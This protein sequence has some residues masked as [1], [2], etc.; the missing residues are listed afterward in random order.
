MEG[1][2]RIP[3]QLPPL[4]EQMEGMNFFAELSTVVAEM[5][6]REQKNNE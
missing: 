1:R 5:P 2:T 4:E 6:W 3:V